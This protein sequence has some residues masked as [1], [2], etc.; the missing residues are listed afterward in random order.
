M[1]IINYKS[2][3]SLGGLEYPKI[4]FYEVLW[5]SDDVMHQ[6]LGGVLKPQKWRVFV[7]DSEFLKK[8]CA[9]CVHSLYFF[10]HMYLYII[11]KCWC[12]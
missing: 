10:V 11:D 9:L 6:T 12:S 8:Q 1:Q 2:I 4:V 3:L 7:Y 5:E